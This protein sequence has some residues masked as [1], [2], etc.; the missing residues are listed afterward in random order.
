M[1]TRTLRT[2]RTLRSS[3]Y[4]ALYGQR[5]A[6][7]V[8]L[9]VFLLAATSARAN[10]R[11]EKMAVRLQAIVDALRSELA[12]PEAVKLELV[13]KNPLMASV[14]PAKEG[15]GFVLA[16]EK[17]FASRLSDAE[18]KSVIAH[19]L[20]HVWIFTHHPYLQTEQL[21]NRIAMR[22]VS[23]QSLEQVYDKVW[24]NGAKGDLGRFLGVS[25]PTEAASLST[26]VPAKDAT[27]PA[28]ATEPSTVIRH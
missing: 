4:P 12:I 17:K 24:K 27:V 21:A 8:W 19:E 5:A 9:P 25:T 11:P 18:L 22:L 6:L 14:E 26:N 13:R 10:E 20:G 3:L 2:L 7:A 23:R 16:I 28:K 15:D 1:S